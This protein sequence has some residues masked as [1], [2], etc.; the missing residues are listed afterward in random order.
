MMKDPKNAISCRIVV[1]RI[2]YVAVVQL[3]AKLPLDW[4]FFRFLHGQ[5]LSPIPILALENEA[6]CSA[7][8]S[9]RDESMHG[10]MARKISAHEITNT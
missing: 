5:F 4:P 10:R 2:L 7:Q 6:K 9:N 8:F 3:F 1:G